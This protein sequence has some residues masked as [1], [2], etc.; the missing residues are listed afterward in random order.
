MHQHQHQ[1]LVGT[2][3]EPAIAVVDEGGSLLS[4]NGNNNGPVPQSLFRSNVSA[5]HLKAKW[6]LLGHGERRIA[7]I[8]AAAATDSVSLHQSR[9]AASKGSESDED[10]DS[11]S[12]GARREDSSSWSRLHRDSDRR[13]PRR[14]AKRDHEEAQG[15][16]DG[17]AAVAA[18][19][20]DDVHLTGK[21]ETRTR[22][23]W[24][25]NE[26]APDGGEGR[27][28][29]E[30]ADCAAS[31]SAEPGATDGEDVGATDKPLTP[32][33]TSLVDSVQNVLPR[34]ENPN[35]IMNLCDI[36][37]KD[38]DDSCYL[39]YYLA[40]NIGAT[41][42]GLAAEFKRCDEDDGTMDT[43]TGKD[44]LRGLGAASA[45][46]EHFKAFPCPALKVFLLTIVTS[47]FIVNQKH[48]NGMR[49]KL[50][51][52]KLQ[53]E[54]HKL[55]IVVSRLMSS[56]SSMLQATAGETKSLLPQPLLVGLTLLLDGG[57]VSDATLNALRVLGISI[58]PE[59]ARRALR[60][61]VHTP[62]HRPCC[63]LCVVCCAFCSM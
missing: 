44:V 4:W 62:L 5:G 49:F 20:G 22:K 41:E 39:A 12:L 52:K 32:L 40:K 16:M 46:M 45:S 23:L 14:P 9:V 28:K 50:R 27:L 26:A 6:S 35:I 48:V 57:G 61:C 36:D 31:N 53:E 18:A 19:G 24:G 25:S 38:R 59:N 33:L 55:D 30:S 21:L 10:S 11:D 15:T 63:V 1:S 51:A 47:Q 8:E 2:R 42:L 34:K 58:G 60:Q 29:G 3:E 43:Q 37:A 7:C 17:A 54:R 56:I 13:L